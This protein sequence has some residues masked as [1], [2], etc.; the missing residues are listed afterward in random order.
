MNHLYIA[1]ADT[2]IIYLTWKLKIVTKVAERK[3]MIFKLKKQ[4]EAITAI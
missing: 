2:R 3:V 1:Y 4:I